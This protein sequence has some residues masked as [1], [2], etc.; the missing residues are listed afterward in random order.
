MSDEPTAVESARDPADDRSDLEQA[1]F[2]IEALRGELLFDEELTAGLCMVSEHYVVS[3]LSFLQLAVSDL[4]KA[5]LWQHQALS[6][7]H[8]AQKKKGEPTP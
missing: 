1:A 5:D 7:R 4:R 3:A 2:A 6:E 8:A